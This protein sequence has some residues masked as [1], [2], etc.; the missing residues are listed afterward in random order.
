MN[1]IKRIWNKIKKRTLKFASQG[2]GLIILGYPV[3][4]INRN[5]HIGDN[6][7]LYPNVSFLGDG[8]IF[9]GNKVKIGN[10][11]IIH[12]SK[13]SFVKISDNTIIAANTYIIDC[14]HKICREQIIQNQGFDVAP[15]LIEEDVWIGASCVIGKGATIK[16]GAV[17]GANSFVNREVQEYAIVAGS[18]AKFIKIRE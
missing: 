10:N 2:S 14:N 8:E 4:L 18:P 7:H 15:V 11:C 1:I 5:V 6:V 17:I 3:Y 16:K 9:I 12:A 13:G